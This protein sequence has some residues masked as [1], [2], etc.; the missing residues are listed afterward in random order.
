MENK[1][2]DGLFIKAPKPN[3]PEFVKASI[4]IKREEFHR[5]IEQQSGDWLNL[6]VKEPKSGKWYAS[7]ND[8]KPAGGM[9]QMPTFNTPAPLPAYKE[10]DG[11][12]DIPF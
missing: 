11:L 1:F 8:W 12:E 10:D 2:V 3:S 5:W 7:L 6:D 9:P 4:S